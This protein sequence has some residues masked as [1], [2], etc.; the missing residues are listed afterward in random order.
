MTAGD[1]ET[2]ALG[3]SLA[4]VDWDGDGRTDILAGAPGDPRCETCLGR[5]FLYL[6]GEDGIPDTP[7]AS[8]TDGDPGGGFG[9]A[10][11]AGDVDGDGRPD[12]LSSARSGRG[13]VVVTGL[14][15]QG[16]GGVRSVLEGPSEW[17]LAA[18]SL[19]LLDLG[20][21]P[22]LVAV[23]AIQGVPED[24]RTLGVVHSWALPGGAH[25]VLWGPEAGVPLLGLT[26]MGAGDFDG[27]G[28]LELA[29][30]TG[31]AG[32]PARTRGGILLLALDGGPARAPFLG[33]DGSRLGSS[34]VVLGDLNGDGGAELA[35][36]SPYAQHGGDESGYVV[37]LGFDQEQRG[38]QPLWESGPELDQAG[39]G[40]ALAAGCRDDGGILMAE[41]RGRRALR[42]SE[43]T[44]IQVLRIGASLQPEVVAEFKPRSR[45]WEYGDAMV[46]APVGGRCRLVV[47]LPTLR[48]EQGLVGAIASFEVG[49]REEPGE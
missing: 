34:G 23:G 30:G 16:F 38:L 3:A 17:A 26:L 20:G 10:I 2:R 37:L 6:T 28:D 7:S 1:G 44:V 45:E 19:Q 14:G 13:V 27:D 46:L 43:G 29:V 49:P 32:L 47:G 48:T 8:M 42:S 40:R 18:R 11:A 36:G 41:S 22:E 31:S 12:L 24:P 15:A 25:R 4:A 5:V 39:R 9:Q 33:P 21:G 35:A